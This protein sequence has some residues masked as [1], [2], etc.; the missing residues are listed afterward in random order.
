MAKILMPEAS[1]PARA[2][3]LHLSNEQYLGLAL[4]A[5]LKSK[6]SLERFPGALV[7]RHYSKDEVIYW[8]GDAG[9]TAFYVLGADEVLPLREAELEACSLAGPGPAQARVAALVQ[10]VDRLRQDVVAS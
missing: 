6:P 9:W 3:D 5:N 4:F 1:L 2:G 7:V 8:Q 10:E